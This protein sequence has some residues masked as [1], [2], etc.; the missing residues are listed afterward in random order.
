[1]V[2][3]RTLAA[4]PLFAL[5]AACAG[6]TGGQAQ[7]GPAE[8]TVEVTTPGSTDDRPSATDD[9][10]RTTDPTTQPGRTTEPNR[11]T[12]PDR[13]SEPAPTDD[14]D[15]PSD[16]LDDLGPFVTGQ[17][18]ELVWDLPVDTTGWTDLELEAPG[19]AQFQLDGTSCLVTLTQPFDE[20]LPSDPEELVD[21]VFDQLIDVL[22]KGAPSQVEPTDSIDLPVRGT[23]LSVALFGYSIA[24]D[25]LLV[26]EGHALV[27]GRYGLV[28]YSVCG[29][30]DADLLDDEVEDFVDDLGIIAT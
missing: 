16:D 22:S 26:G 3:I 27:S 1:M 19:E 7:A 17:E 28:V 6:T 4:L 29:L 24:I 15:L 23:N 25:D 9:P 12:E 11:T 20:N 2:R 14:D 18:Q 21:S 13:T 10:D 8:N 5:L 30:S